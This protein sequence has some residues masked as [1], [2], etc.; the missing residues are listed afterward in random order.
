MLEHGK[1]DKETLEKFTGETLGEARRLAAVLLALNLP[2][3]LEAYYDKDAEI[4]PHPMTKDATEKFCSLLTAFLDTQSLDT[5][6]ANRD[7]AVAIVALRDANIRHM[8]LL[9]AYADR[10]TIYEYVLNRLEHRFSGKTLP[11]GYS[12]EA[13]TQKILDALSGMQDKAARQ[14]IL[15]QLIEQLP[16]RM[17]KKRFFQIVS[18]GLDVYKGSEK[19]TVEDLVYMIRTAAL[20]EEPEG[21]QNDYKSLYKIAERLT[22]ADYTKL[23]QAQ[24]EVLYQ[25]AKA[26][27][28]E[29]NRQMDLVMALQELLN[30]LTVLTLTPQTN[31][32]EDE[33]KCFDLISETL[34]SYQTAEGMKEAQLAG[35]EKLEGIQEEASARFMELSAAADEFSQAYAKEIESYGLNHEFAV[36]AQTGRLLSSSRFASL[37]IE[38]NSVSETADESYIASVYSGLYRELDAQFKKLPRVMNRAV[39]AKILT[40]FPLFIREY[41]ELESYISTSL[42]SCTDEAEKLA[43]LEIMDD[44]LGE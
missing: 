5:Q 25:H 37:S 3:Y 41:Q 22:A 19:K 4:K 28:E 18:D 6:T 23:D 35:F 31:A 30:E 34:D 26:G 11:E 21:M 8:H 14:S 32:D 39:M 7:T 2:S 38:T 12:D 36:L 1:R 20:L 29:L 27:L 40:M 10:F 42:A 17:T 16:M 44:L 33:T 15:V 24:F 43:C 13:Q 9:S